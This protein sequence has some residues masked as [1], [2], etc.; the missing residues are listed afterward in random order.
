[1]T[2]TTLAKKIVIA[3]ISEIDPQCDHVISCVIDF[4]LQRK[5]ATRSAA[6]CV[7]VEPKLDITRL[8][9]WSIS[10][11]NLSENSNFVEK[12]NHNFLLKSSEIKCVILRCAKFIVIGNFS[13]QDFV[14]EKS[15][16]RS[17]LAQAGILHAVVGDTNGVSAES[18]AK[19]C[20]FSFLH[21]RKRSG[22]FDLGLFSE[23]WSGGTLKSC[24]SKGRSS[25]GALYMRSQFFILSPKYVVTSDSWVPTKS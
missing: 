7:I 25:L 6:G 9:C 19:K 13:F 3:E 24:F 17:K 21:I 23:S 2:C 5:P 16:R 1:M 20:H 14:L 12:C 11:I 8:H 15:S 22:Y 18:E 4:Y 10:R